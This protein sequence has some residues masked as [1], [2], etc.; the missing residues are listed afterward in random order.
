MLCLIAVSDVWKTSIMEEFPWCLGKWIFLGMRNIK[1]NE[2]R[3]NE[4]GMNLVVL[5]YNVHVHSQ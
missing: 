3:V 2:D 4:E 1:H 5:Q